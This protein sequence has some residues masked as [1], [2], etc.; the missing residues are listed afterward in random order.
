MVTEDTGT[1]QGRG[2]QS[3][4][5]WGGLPLQAWVELGSPDPQD[6]VTVAVASEKL[7]ALYRA[8]SGKEGTAPKPG[9]HGAS[10]PALGASESCRGKSTAGWPRADQGWGQAGTWG[11][12]V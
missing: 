12:P 11:T 10:R 3:G 9:V 5:A 2:R 4:E 8:G 6:R 7:V 1:S